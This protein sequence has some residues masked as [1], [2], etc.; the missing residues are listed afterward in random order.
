MLTVSVLQ[1][2][3]G[4]V[5]WKKQ[6]QTADSDQISKPKLV[7]GISQTWKLQQTSERMTLSFGKF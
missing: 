4:H 3:L 6:E 1:P 7:K 5:G 2:Q